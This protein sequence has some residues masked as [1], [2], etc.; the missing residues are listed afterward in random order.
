[1]LTRKTKAVRGSTPKSLVIKCTCGH[2]I[3]LLPDVEAMSQAIETH[4][5]EHT[6]TTNDAAE[7]DRIR[8][9]LISQLFK[10]IFESV[11]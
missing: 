2:T 11:K 9:E 4:I 1:M 3:L 8:A 6:N 10:K 5:S 7:A